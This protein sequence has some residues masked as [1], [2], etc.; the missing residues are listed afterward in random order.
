MLM[1]KRTDRYQGWQYSCRLHGLLRP[2]HHKVDAD[3]VAKLH[4]MKLH[5]TMKVNAEL[6]KAAN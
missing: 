4:L 5:P 1:L 3:F 6:T 2:R